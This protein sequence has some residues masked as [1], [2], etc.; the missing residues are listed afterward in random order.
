MLLLTSATCLILAN[1]YYAQPILADIAADIGLERGATGMIVTMSQIGYMLGLLFLAPLGDTVENRRLVAGMTAGAASGLLVAGLSNGAALFMA[2]T[3]LIGF[4]AVGT[5]ILIVFGSGLAEDSARGRVLGIL[6]AGLFL[7]IALARPFSSLFTSAFGW[8]ALYLTSGAVML[9]FSAALYCS[10]PPVKPAGRRMGYAAMFGSMAR[11]LLSVPRFI[12]R[13]LLSAGAFCGFSMFWSAAPLHLLEN[14][15]F[16]H[17]QVAL[18]ALAGLIT[19]PCVLMAGR[20][21]DRGWS[22]RLLLVAEGLAVAAWLLTSWMPLS[23]GAVALAAL[24][25]DP[26]GSVSTMSIQQSVLS[27]S[28]PETRG[29]LNSLNISLNFCGGA[30]GAALGPW[31][32]S[33]HGWRVMAGAGAALMLMLLLVNMALRPTRPR[34]G[35]LS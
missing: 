35:N 28:L 33:L 5:Q 9:A 22:F 21:L 26:A 14:L 6:G 34:P 8:R 2:G 32:Y 18:F 10:L 23:A 11:L 30:M 15:G 27:T 25:I 19:P 12:P 13:I 4:F 1:L 20:L 3:L 31:L 16:T 17:A 29:R 7:G 24:I